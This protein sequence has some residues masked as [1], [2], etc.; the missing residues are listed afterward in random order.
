MSSEKVTESAIATMDTLNKSN[1]RPFIVTMMM[2]TVVL[3]I[4]TYCICILGLIFGSEAAND[5]LPS[6]DE[7]LAILAI[8]SLIITNYFKRRTE[9][10]AAKLNA[11]NGMVA[12]PSLV[13]DV[14]S[15]F[16]EK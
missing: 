9:D 14:V 7:I 11:L 5:K 16:K 15:K 13:G 3:Y 10:K 12:K 2:W 8:P 6:Y 4:T 1:S